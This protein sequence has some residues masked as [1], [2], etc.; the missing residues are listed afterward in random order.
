MNAALSNESSEERLKKAIA[1]LCYSDV[2]KTAA[3]T[4]FLISS[5]HILTCAHVVKGILKHKSDSSLKEPE[6]SE[7]ELQFPFLNGEEMFLASEVVFP[8]IENHTIEQENCHKDFAILKLKSPLPSD[9]S[10]IQLDEKGYQDKLAVVSSGFRQSHKQAMSVEGIAR[11]AVTFGLHSIQTNNGEPYQIDHGYSGAPVWGKGS[12]ERVLGMIVAKE[13][14]PD[15][16]VAFFIPSYILLENIPKEYIPPKYYQADER[17]PKS[18]HSNYK[19]Y[20]DNIADAL[21]EGNVI[22]VFGPGLDPDFYLSLEKKLADFI[23]EKLYEGGN[24]SYKNLEINEEIKYQERHQRMKLISQ[25]I[26]LPCSSCHYFIEHR[27]HES[28]NKDCPMLEG[29]LSGSITL[30]DPLYPVFIEQQLSIAM[31]NIR[32]LSEYYEFLADYSTFYLKLKNILSEIESSDP[33]EVY[34]FFHEFPNKME[35]ANLPKDYPGQPYDLMITTN[36]VFMKNYLQKPIKIFSEV[37]KGNTGDIVKFK[38]MRGNH[39]QDMKKDSE[40]AKL[41]SNSF[42]LASGENLRCQQRQPLLFQLYGNL[43]GH[44][45][46]SKDHTNALIKRLS[47]LPNIIN[48]AIQERPLLFLGFN[49][50]DYELQQIVNFFAV[51]RGIKLDGWLVYQD[52]PRTEFKDGHSENLSER[53]WSNISK[54]KLLPIRASST[55]QISLKDFIHDLNHKID[56]KLKEGDIP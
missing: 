56:L 24:Q 31:T 36:Y 47:N 22:P 53:I 44:C 41:D 16:P 25:V 35:K 33:F 43:E 5:Q 55:E 32:H 52:I 51:S 4:G 29:L 27:G 30:N 28:D 37:T 11:G 54:I 46:I 39:K 45:V 12:P 14:D 9:M 15:K 8:E 38:S 13:K 34:K 10:F 20:L 7:I 48:T 6:K 49:K 18:I 2:Q 21:I 19:Q 40:P 23:L 3:G 17:F 50:N 42:F 26:G 1:R